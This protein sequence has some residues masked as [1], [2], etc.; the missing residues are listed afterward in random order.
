M[1]NFCLAKTDYLHFE[2]VIFFVFGLPVFIPL[3]LQRVLA[4][5]EGDKIQRHQVLP[6]HPILIYTLYLK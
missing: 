4:K 2:L 3:K 5:E 1:A 6:P